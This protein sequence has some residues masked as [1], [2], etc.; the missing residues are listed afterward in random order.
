MGVTSGCNFL[1]RKMKAG[2]GSSEKESVTSD[3]KAKLSLEAMSLSDI[4]DLCL[5]CCSWWWRKCGNVGLLVHS[6][7]EKDTDPEA[8]ANEQTESISGSSFN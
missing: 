4:R 6:R 5:C 3:I 2:N 1:G 7:D 8:E